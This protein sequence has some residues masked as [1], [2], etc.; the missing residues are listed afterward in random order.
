MKRKYYIQKIDRRRNVVV[1]CEV[2][3]WH[4]VT[5]ITFCENPIK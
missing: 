5:C 4:G 3:L 2:W 1:L